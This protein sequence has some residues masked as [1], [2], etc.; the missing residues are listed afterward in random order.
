MS[1]TLFFDRYPISGLSTSVHPKRKGPAYYAD[2]IKTYVSLK[3][4]YS[5]ASAAGKTDTNVRPL[6]PL[7]NF[8]LPSTVAN[9]VWSLP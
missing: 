9:K 5:A 2:P 6:K 4:A 8:T 3:S 1:I 7:W